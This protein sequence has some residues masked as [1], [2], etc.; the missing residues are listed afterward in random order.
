MDVVLLLAAAMLNRY[1][2]EQ[3]RYRAIDQKWGVGNI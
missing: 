2:K 1:R 3:L